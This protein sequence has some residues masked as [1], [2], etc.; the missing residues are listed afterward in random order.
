MAWRVVDAQVALTRALELGATEY[1]GPGKS[2]EAPAVLG[3][4]GS[5]LY[6]IDRYGDAG[7]AYDADYDWIGETDPRPEG[8]GF[9][10]LD[11]LTHNVIRGNMDTWYKFYHDTFNFRE[12]RFFDIKASRPGWS[13][14]P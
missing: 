14:A 1:T 12:I 8:F 2:I 4:G 9:F 10:Y 3:I 6:F 7:S 5:L 11:H 13:A